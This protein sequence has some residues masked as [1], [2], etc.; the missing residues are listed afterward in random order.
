MF[1]NAILGSSQMTLLGD[2]I[3]RLEAREHGLPGAVGNQIDEND[4]A[5][6]ASSVRPWE[7]DP[8]G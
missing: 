1:E 5:K 7:S 2:A 8:L 3:Q 4:P 6:V